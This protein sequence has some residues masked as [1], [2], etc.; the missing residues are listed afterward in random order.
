MHAVSAL[1][2]LLPLSVPPLWPIRTFPAGASPLERLSRSCSG[3]R[4]DTIF[5]GWEFPCDQMNSFLSYYIYIS[6]SK[7]L[8]SA[9]FT[10]TSYPVTLIGHQPKKTFYLYYK[11]IKD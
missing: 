7:V 5:G 11:H 1:F 10:K 4:P 3:R 2:M 6:F 9:S 8:S